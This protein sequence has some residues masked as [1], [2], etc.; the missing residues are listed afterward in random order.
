MN[1]IYLKHRLVYH[2]PYQNSSYTQKNRARY[3]SGPDRVCGGRDFLSY[4]KFSSH[5]YTHAFTFGNQGAQKS[6]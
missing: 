1:K 6:R 4:T 5:M 2:I 3:L